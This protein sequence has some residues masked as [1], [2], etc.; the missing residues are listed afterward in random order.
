MCQ[1]L[2]N[3]VC[4][5]LCVFECICASVCM[6]ACGC[7]LCVQ[8]CV[9]Q[10]T[11]CISQGQGSQDSTLYQLHGGDTCLFQRQLSTG[12]PERHAPLCTH[13]SDSADRKKRRR[14][15]HASKKRERKKR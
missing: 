1:S 3:S 5:S 9:E 15:A 8:A 12:L 10:T 4:V 11:R 14:E 7:V 2:N 6:C 13:Q